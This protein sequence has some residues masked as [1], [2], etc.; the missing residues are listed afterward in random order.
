MATNS[1]NGE[2]EVVEENEKET[3]S[4]ALKYDFSILETRSTGEI[5]FPCSRESPLLV[6]LF[7]SFVSASLLQVLIKRRSYD[8]VMPGLYYEVADLHFEY[9][10]WPRM[11][12]RA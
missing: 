8:S 10:R 12:A 2:V 11:S 9:P 4:A 6:A 7:P 1:G 5:G 3:T